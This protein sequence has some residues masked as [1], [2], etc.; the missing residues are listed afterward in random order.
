M[1]KISP[2]L[3]T[4]TVIWGNVELACTRQFRYARAAENSSFSDG[5]YLQ[6]SPRVWCRLDSADLHIPSEK[7]C[8]CKEEARF[9]RGCKE[10]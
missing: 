1:I 7:T 3:N 8:G 10:A 9:A 2:F 4:V 6:F 5:I